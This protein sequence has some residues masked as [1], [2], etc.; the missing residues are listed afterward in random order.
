MAQVKPFR[1]LL[2]NPDLLDDLSNI[3]C[4]PYDVIS[5]QMQTELYQRSPY[6]MVR[7]EE[8]LNNSTDND[9]NNRYTRAASTLQKWIDSKI[10]IRDTNPAFYVLNHRFS[11]L[12]L[13][14]ISES[15]RP[16]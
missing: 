14:H 10:L 5:S 16:Y 2:Y 8:G 9:C 7:L 13:I 1:G 4:P 6:N 12:S 3:I 15:T 11:Y